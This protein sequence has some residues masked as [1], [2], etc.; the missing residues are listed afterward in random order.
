M[1]LLVVLIVVFE[2]IGS[3]VT[4]LITTFMYAWSPSLFLFEPKVSL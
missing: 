1:I 4:I 2:G 3:Y